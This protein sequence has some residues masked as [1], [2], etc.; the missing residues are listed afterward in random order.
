MCFLKVLV[1][2]EGIEE[3]SSEEAV[4]I[5][6][7]AN[8]CPGFRGILKQRLVLLDR[9]YPLKERGI[10]SFALQIHMLIRC[11]CFAIMDITKN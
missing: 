2:I 8:S 7:Y 3:M 9:H 4:G 6:A 11:I 5:L 10:V 1:C